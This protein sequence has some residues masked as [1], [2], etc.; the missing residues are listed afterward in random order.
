M[1][2]VVTALAIYQLPFNLERFPDRAIG[3]TIFSDVNPWFRSQIYVLS[4]LLGL[5]LAMAL[6]LGI[7]V[8]SSRR[9]GQQPDIA[10]GTMHVLLLAC[11]LLNFLAWVWSGDRQPWTGGMLLSAL[12]LALRFVYPGGSKV[13]PTSDSDYLVDVT[14]AWQGLTLLYMWQGWDTGYRFLALWSGLACLLFYLRHHHRYSPSTRF[15][16]LRS[17]L[18]L[19]PL[20]LVLASELAFLLSLYTELLFLLLASVFY[21]VCLMRKNAVSATSSGA[22]LCVLMT[23]IVINE[24]T[25]QIEF[26]HAYDLFHLGERVIPLQQWSSF[27][28]MPYIDYLPAHGL[29]DVFPQF[30]YQKIYGANALD[31]LYWGNGYF[32]G[33]GMRVLAMGITWWFFSRVMRPEMAFFLLW[34]LPS[35]HL[36][37]PYY[38][39][40]V[41]PAINILAAGDR[42]GDLRWWVRQVLAGLLLLLWRP[43]FGFAAIAASLCVAALLSWYRSSWRDLTTAL[44]TGLMGV[45]LMLAVFGWLAGYA[46][47]L[48]KLALMASYL[49]NQVPVASYNAFYEVLDLTVFMQYVFLPVSVVLAAAWSV[50]RVALRKSVGIALRLDLVIAFLAAISL[51][52]S[53]RALQRHS[54]LEELFQH[55]FYL[56]TLLVFVVRQCIFRLNSRQLYLVL[57][58]FIM[59][60]YLS[61]PK[62]D[63][64]L[65]QSIY[66]YAP[67]WEYPANA[68]GRSWNGRSLPAS[69]L[70]DSTLGHQGVVEYLRTQL[71]PGQTFFEFANAHML[72][73]LVDVP[74]P[75]YITQSIYLS[76]ASVQEKTRAWLEN[77]IKKGQLP[78]VIFKQNSVWDAADGVENV[79]R[80]YELSEFIYGR[81]R[82]C[83]RVDQFELWL[84]IGRSA[85][86]VCD[87][88][89]DA[90]N[91]VTTLVG[92][93]PK[94]FVDYGHIPR[95]W[96]NYDEHSEVIGR[97][98]VLSFKKLDERSWSA[99]WNTF[100]DCRSCY[101]DLR[102]LSPVDQRMVL[103]LDGVESVAL[104]LVAGEHDYRIRISSLW[105]WHQM[106]PKPSIEMKAETGVGLLSGFIRRVDH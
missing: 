76:T 83:I 70:V 78:L 27:G 106:A 20:L 81:Y 89:V 84:E 18:L 41:L 10:P 60:S 22:A 79:L 68:S 93:S 55:Y 29:F 46:G 105:G 52:I 38:V 99:R 43:D 17:W 30:I 13:R 23:T 26:R 11:A 85:K 21:G 63:S 64:R 49:K 48:H 50:T 96:A 72:Y 98:T 16:N 97:S 44:L 104:Q 58:S 59:L 67:M 102:I 101:M 56:A 24:Y 88:T 45:L 90:A 2:A 25:P 94:Q 5:S 31:S 74:L 40:L 37:E 3:I 91:T 80:S 32:F 95:I 6:F 54:L 28:H 53:V 100:E 14:V 39:L 12:L 34:L 86:G 8:G 33:W 7:R 19:A 92:S 51:M 66:R 42:L 73:A 57:A 69:R 87:V 1:A 36:I 62:I 15:S 9:L 65:M 35:Y 77:L 71:E 4:V 82:P 103:L 75:V 47:A 61:M